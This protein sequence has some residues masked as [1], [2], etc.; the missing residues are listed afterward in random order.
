MSLS[1]P[2]G[3]NEQGTTRRKRGNR[4][5]NR[6]EISSK[7]RRRRLR[8]KKDMGEGSTCGGV[9]GGNTV[10]RDFW[11]WGGPA[12]AEREQF[13]PEKREGIGAGL[14]EEGAAGKNGVGEIDVALVLGR[15]MGGIHS[16]GS[17][18]GKIA[19][20]E[21]GENFLKDEFRLFCVE[22][23]QA[24]SVFQAAEGGFDAPAHGVEPPQR[25]YRELLGIQVG[26][27]GFHAA[28]S[29]LQADDSEG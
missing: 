3:K 13:S 2:L 27:E 12:R 19:N 17:S 16:P 25:G 9:A 6:R 10:T 24:N 15:A 11:S 26:D 5:S 8:L 7:M 18:L 4:G 23:D 28:A 29:G 1:W 20:E 21:T 22:M 14:P